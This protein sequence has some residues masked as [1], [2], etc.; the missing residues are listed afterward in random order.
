VDTNRYTRLRGLVHGVNRQRKIQARKIDI[1]CNDMV[2]AHRAMLE[3]LDNLAFAGRLHESLIGHSSAPDILTALSTV[4]AS[5]F[6]E[7]GV[8]VLLLELDGITLHD[9]HAG[10][11]D[12]VAGLPSYFTVENIRAICAST[13]TYSITELL[14]LPVEI[15]PMTAEHTTASAI[16]LKLAHNSMG[17]VLLYNEAERPLAPRL[18]STTATAAPAIARALAAVRP[19]SSPR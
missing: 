1:L 16:P 4:L 14:T 11:S 9:T 8:A 10:L 3:R 7:C 15:P 19:V 12:E 18:V 17:I 2:G 5:R 6:G 13:R